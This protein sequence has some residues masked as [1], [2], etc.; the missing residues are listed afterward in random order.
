MR[1]AF[2]FCVFL[3]APVSTNGADEDCIGTTVATTS[4][5]FEHY[6]T[7]D[8]NLNTVYQKALKSA[9]HYGPKGID[10]LRDAQRKWIAYRD[11]ACEAEYSLFGG[12]SGGPGAKLTCLLRITGRRIED[13]K[14]SYFL[15]EKSK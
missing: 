9:A 6:K 8:A 2:V 11:A 12:G 1:V 3:I 13:L 10:Y 15:D 4:C 5:L 7:A 14:S